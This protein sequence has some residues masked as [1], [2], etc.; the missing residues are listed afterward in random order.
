MK[1]T[2]EPC[3]ENYGPPSAETMA[4]A[5]LLCLFKQLKTKAKPKNPL[6][7]HTPVI[8]ALKMEAGGL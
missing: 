3:E 6:E 8:P 5:T 1:P 4:P 2:S 7:V